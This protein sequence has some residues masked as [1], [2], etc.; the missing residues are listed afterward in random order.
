MSKK[1][2]HLDRRTF[3]KGLGVTCMLPY[4]EAMS[5]TNLS[6]LSE[7]EATK[8]LCF[9]YF[10]NGVGLPPKDSEYY[11]DWSWF[12]IG[13]GKNYKLTKSLYHLE[14]HRNNMSIIGGLSHPN[15]ELF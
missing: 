13:E 8:R 4:F 14:R 15:R 11:K 10:P 1:S 9:L 7:P 6:K 3:L 5:M 12:P 2:W